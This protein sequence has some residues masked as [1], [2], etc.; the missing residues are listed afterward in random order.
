MHLRTAPYDLQDLRA[1]ELVAFLSHIMQRQQQ[2]LSDSK[3]KSSYQG[4][5]KLRRVREGE[6]RVGLALVGFGTELCP[7]ARD[8]LETSLDAGNGAAGVACLALQEVESC[9]LLEDG[10][11]G[12]ACMAR[13]I[14]LCEER[15]RNWR[16]TGK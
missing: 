4:H 9:V 2:T 13:H 8:S 10:V 11:R 7:L 12:A 1:S 5:P 3:Q 14:L 6:A 15:E 16:E